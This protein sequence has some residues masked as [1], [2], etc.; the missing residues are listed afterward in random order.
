M[1]L[2]AMSLGAQQSPPTTH[3][4]ARARPVRTTAANF[5]AT[6]IGGRGRLF[7]KVRA[8][9]FLEQLLGAQQGGQRCGMPSS[10]DA[11]PGGAVFLSAFYIFPVRPDLVHIFH[12]HIS[13]HVRMSPDDLSAIRRAT[14]TKSNAPRSFANWQ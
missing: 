1:T 5:D 4:F 10:E 3:G 6:Q 14:A 11:A 8:T 9:S 2:L 12:M 13:K 7:R